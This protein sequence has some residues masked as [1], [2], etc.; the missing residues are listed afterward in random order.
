MTV[1]PSTAER[2]TPLLRRGESVRH[3]IPVMAEIMGVVSVSL[4]ETCIVVTDERVLVVTGGLLRRGGPAKVD[5]EFSRS[6]RLGPLDSALGPAIT[7]GSV[8]Y[9]IDDD[10][11]PLVAVAD[12][13]LADSRPEDAERR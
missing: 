11:A 4:N 6:T 9:E 2:F 7:L 13:E 10:A 8:T 12:A 5:R 1:A 3:V